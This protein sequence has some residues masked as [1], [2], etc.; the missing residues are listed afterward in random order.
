MN[1][2]GSS[3]SFLRKRSSMIV[4]DCRI[5]S[6]LLTQTVL[7]DWQ[8]VIHTESTFQFI[9]SSVVCINS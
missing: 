9:W 2:N 6:D 4:V 8:A 3:F 5:K 1:T 7:A